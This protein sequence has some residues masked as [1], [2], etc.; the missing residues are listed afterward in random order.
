M[1]RDTK[2]WLLLWH[3]RVRIYC[4]ERGVCFGK[5]SMLGR[6]VYR[7][8]SCAGRDWRLQSESP[9]HTRRLNQTRY[10]PNMDKECLFISGQ[11]Q[12]VSTY[13]TIGL[14]NQAFPTEMNQWI[15]KEMKAKCVTGGTKRWIKIPSF[16][17][18]Y[19]LMHHIFIK[20]LYKHTK[21][22]N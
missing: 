12:A 4:C 21:T 19:Q 13:G 14:P 5:I 17:L 3:K 10:P 11:P 9:S 1:G 20:T 18:S 22:V 2:H 15:T 6:Q 16:H 7:L 8:Q